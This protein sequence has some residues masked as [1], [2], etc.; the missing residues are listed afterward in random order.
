M[1]VPSYQMRNVLNAYS[2][3]LRQNV[4]STGRIRMAEQ[5]P[6]NRMNRTTGKK[7]RAAN[8]RVSKAI[9]EKIFRYGSLDATHPKP[10]DPAKDNAHQ[11][12]SALKEN[13]AKFVF[14]AIDSI[15]NKKTNTLFV[16]DPN[17]FNRGLS[18][19]VSSCGDD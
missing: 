1:Y 16:E 15:N 10:T 8:E 5:P 11:E 6:A 9:L 14:N 3:Q 18:Q 2:E 4:G 13:K 17:F 12:T 7:P 19:A